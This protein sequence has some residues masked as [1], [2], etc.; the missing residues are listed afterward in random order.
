MTEINWNAVSVKDFSS[1][2][3]VF[4]NAGKE[5]NGI[6]VTFGDSVQKIPAYAFYE[7]TSLTS[8][9]IGDSVTSIGSGAFGDCTSLDDVYYTSDIASWL[10]IS[11]GN[12]SANPLSRGANLYLNGEL[13]TDI[14]IPDSVTSIGEYAFAGCTAEINWG[15]NPTIG[16][17][18]S[19]AF[20]D[21][22]GTSITI[23]DS[24]TS[25]GEYAFAGCTSLTSVTIPDS[26]TSIESYAFSGCYSLTIYCEAAS[27][28]SGWDSNWNYSDC[29]VVWDA[30]N[31][32]VADDGY[33]Y[34]IDENGLRYALKGTTATVVRQARNLRGNIEI[35]ASVSYKGITYSVTSIGDY[36]FYGCTSLTSVTIPDSVTSI[37]DWAFYSCSSLT[38]VTFEGTV[39]QWKAIR[40]GSYWNEYSLFTKVVCSD[41]TV[42]GY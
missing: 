16:T 41:G 10:S 8:V 11:F 34:Y 2:S 7:C 21:Y 42:G 9:T 31:S 12:A 28:P 1:S 27:K 6:T 24:V 38:S 5:E 39:A 40:K 15:N 30:N 29:P 18:G 4:Y 36:A 32:D 13:A 20:S 22:R 14:V 37:G 23:P 17:I 19:Y 35:P 3:D 25:I 26:V 33:I